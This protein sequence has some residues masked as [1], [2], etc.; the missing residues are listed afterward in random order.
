MRRDN[1]YYTVFPEYLDQS[2][3]RKQ[4][5]RLAFSQAIKDPTILELRLAAEKLGYEYEIRK[6]AAYPRQWWQNKGLILIEKRDS[7]LT[8]LRNLSQEITSVIRPA[9]EKQ[10]KD[11]A[12]KVKKRKEAP[13]RRIIPK[14]QKKEFRPKRRR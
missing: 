4:G 12:Q 6:D 8:T 14:E 11:L 13:K 2:L 3:T 9:L 7:K 10:K 5:R 1:T